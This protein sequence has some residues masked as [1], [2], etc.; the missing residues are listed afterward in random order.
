MTIMVKV[1]FQAGIEI[2]Y[3]CIRCECIRHKI[4][5]IT[6]YQKTKIFEIKCIQCLNYRVISMP[7]GMLA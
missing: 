1:E 7:E 5:N 3:T 2:A 4:T 6:N